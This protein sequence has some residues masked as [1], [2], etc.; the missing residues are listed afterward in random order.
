MTACGFVIG[1]P[2]KDTHLGGKSSGSETPNMKRITCRLRT[3]TESSMA[4][5]ELIGEV[6]FREREKRRMCVQVK[7]SPP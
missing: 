2:E 7:L 3:F 6:P 1:Q 4:F 5:S